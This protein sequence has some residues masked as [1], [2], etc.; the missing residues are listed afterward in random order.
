[1][2]AFCL[3]PSPSFIL[4]KFS[5]SQYPFGKAPCFQPVKW[6][7]KIDMK[8]I[9]C[10]IMIICLKDSEGDKHDKRLE[11]QKSE[12]YNVKL[13]RK[14]ETHKKDWWKLN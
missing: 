8:I 1:M 14:K 11:P 12:E 13:W 4:K 10:T 9:Q 7:G 6:K 3:H 5:L 2:K